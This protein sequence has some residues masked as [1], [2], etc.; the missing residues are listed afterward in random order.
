MERHASPAVRANWR[1]QQA[2]YRAYYDAYT[3][4]RLLEENRLEEHALAELR[5]AP[6]SGSLAAMNRAEEVLGRERADAIAAS[7]RARV[8]ELAEALFQSIRMQLSV[9]RYQAISVDRGANLDTI[10]VPLNNRLW[11]KQRFAELRQAADET[12][13]LKGLERI[14]HWTDPGPGGFYDGLGNPAQHPHLVRGPETLIGFAGNPSWRT[15]WRRHAESAG[16]APLR[17]RYSDLDP[18]AQYKVRVVYAGDSPR[19]K[20]RLVANEAL[21]VHPLIAKP[22]PPQ[23]LEFDVPPQATASGELN[24]SWYRESGLGG[25]GRG[26]QVSEVWL[27]RK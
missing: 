7:W 8:F 5:D 6:A 20:I 17:M 18:R 25:N 19:V 1:F 22:Q 21:E 14:V 27:I 11:L 12:E 23:P 2:L 13:R 16:D 24:L 26:C 10:D 15:S 9:P 4:S 3:R